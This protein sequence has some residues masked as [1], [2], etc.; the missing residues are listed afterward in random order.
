[1]SSKPV[2]NGQDHM[3]ERK[4]H[5]RDLPGMGEWKVTS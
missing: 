4:G 3:P 5:F 2:C 1:M